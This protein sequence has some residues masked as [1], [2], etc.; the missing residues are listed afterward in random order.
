MMGLLALPAMLRAGYSV[1]LSAGA[2][3]AGGCLGILIP[4]SVML[5][6]YGA[7][8]GV[9]VVKL[10]AGAFFPGIMLAGLYV[11][12]VVV[13]A[14][15]KPHLAPPMPEED[16]LVPLPAFAEVVSRTVS[17]K[18]IPGLVGAI[19]GKR[20]IAVPMSELLKHFGIALL[21]AIATAV[22]M[23]MIYIKV[24][25]A[26]ELKQLKALSQWGGPAF[27]PVIQRVLAWVVYRSLPK[28]VGFS[29]HRQR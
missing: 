9:S 26:V 17:D 22:I 13:I 28:K 4:P 12:Y 27:Q 18:V 7:T 19:K 11:L 14:K 29:R 24:T 10:Y 5:I 25:A 23:G 16:R 2:I 21:P 20:N 1:Q 8:A 3:T 6:V 15:W